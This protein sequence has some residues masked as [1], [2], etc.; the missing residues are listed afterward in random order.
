[1]N[2]KRFRIQKKEN[3]PLLEVIT[4]KN[5]TQKIVDFLKKYCP[6]SFGSPGMATPSAVFVT[7][8][9]GVGKSY[10]L[11][12]VHWKLRNEY[13][14]YRVI[15]ISD[16]ATWANNSPLEFLLTS[17]AFA[18]SSD[19][20]VLEKLNTFNESQTS[21]SDQMKDFLKDLFMFLASY[22]EKKKLYLFSIFDQHNGL[23]NKTRKQLPFSIVEQELPDW[24]T[25]KEHCLVVIA[26]SSN[27]TYFLKYAFNSTW[28]TLNLCDTFNEEEFTFHYNKHLQTY[29]NDKNLVL[30]YTNAMP[31]ELDALANTP[32]KDINIFAD[33]RKNYFTT[34]ETEF[35][36]SLMP[37]AKK[38][39]ALGALYL[40]LGIPVKHIVKF[41]SQLVFFDANR[42]LKAV[43]PFAKDVI[44]QVWNESTAVELES[45]LKT[46][47]QS[48][49]FTNDSKGR[50]VEYYI[51]NCF[52]NLKTFTLDVWAIDDEKNSTYMFFD[53]KTFRFTPNSKSR[54]AEGLKW[55]SDLLLIP[56]TPN[57]EGVDCL[58]W[59]FNTKTLLPMQITVLNPISK[60]TKNLKNPFFTMGSNRNSSEQWAFIINNYFKKEN[61]IKI[62]FVWIG[63]NKS[64]SSSWKG[65]YFALFSSLTSQ[66]PVL[67]YLG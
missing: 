16:C 59:H 34:C 44:I 31:I 64:F 21:T 60:H 26:A 66:M 13:S 48:Q 14:L 27:N 40:E 57:Y 42:V 55:D 32:V 9:I 23:T 4:R 10:G 65:E 53:V 43:S 49:E 8:P 56:S 39:C 63:N 51:L 30:E 41:N 46:I 3:I 33:T 19:R 50:A 11:F 12:E 18:F 24:F 47:F 62:V 6:K 20:E 7:G 25:E 22:C 45:T 29:F 1:M 37:E 15:Y 58:L 38:L 52:S 17:I 2:T 54:V 36:K 5:F 61:L 28:P 67:K 35:M